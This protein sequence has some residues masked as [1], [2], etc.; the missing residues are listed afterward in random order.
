MKGI[1]PR[2]IDLEIR[3]G[4]PGGSE[5]GPTK[6]IGW[7]DPDGVL[8]CSTGRLGMKGIRLRSRVE[9]KHMPS[10]QGTKSANF[11]A[12]KKA[13][14]LRDKNLISTIFH[15]ENSCG[16]CH[17]WLSWYRHP[18]N[19]FARSQCLF[20]QCLFPQ[21]LSA[22]G[23]CSSDTGALY[24]FGRGGTCGLGHGNKTSLAQPARVEALTDVRVE[25]VACGHR[26]IAAMVSS[27]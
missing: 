4:T 24:T 13:S 17:E 25:H 1:L 18:F 16:K 7:A 22:P 2:S 20:S 15:L 21:C 6:L 11:P 9:R 26:H 14:S 10:E 19:T 8:D 3:L 23:G 5:S 27:L 12:P